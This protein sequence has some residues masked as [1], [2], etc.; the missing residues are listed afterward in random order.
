AKWHCVK[1]VPTAK[2]LPGN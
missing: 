2:T 1:R